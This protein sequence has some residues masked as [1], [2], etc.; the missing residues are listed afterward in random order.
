MTLRRLTITVDMPAVAMDSHGV[1]AAMLAPSLAVHADNLATFMR[2]AVVDG[3]MPVTLSSAIDVVNGVSAVQTIACVQAS[4]AGNYVNVLGEVF[5]EA[6]VPSGTNQFTDGADDD[7]TATNLGAVIAAHPNLIGL[8]TVGVV[9]DTVT[10]TGLARSR[11]LQSQ[12][13]TWWHS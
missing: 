12:P 13:T 11:C 4:A 5:L 9:D 3:N 8:V 1:G 7:E 6:D 10:V 2:Q